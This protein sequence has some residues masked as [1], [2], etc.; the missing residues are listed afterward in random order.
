VPQRQLEF[1][2]PDEVVERGLGEIR[3]RLGIPEGFPVEV[4]GDARS[5]EPDLPDEDHTDIPF[6]TIDPPGSRDLDQA[7]HIERRGDGYR[8]RYAIADV[9]AFVRS[10]GP[11]DDEARERGLTMYGPDLRSPLYPGIL[12]EGMASL[13]AD[14][15][16]PA[17]VWNLDLDEAGEPID[18]DLRRAMVRSRGQYD[19]ASVQGQLDDG[20]A[21]TP[22]RLL[23]EVGRLRR[24]LEQERGGV[25][26]PIPDQQVAPYNGGWRLEY[27]SPLPVEGWNAQISLLTGMVAADLMIGAGIG[28]L[29]TLPPPRQEDIDRMRRIAHALEIAWPAHVGYPELVRSLD[30]GIPAHAAMLAEATTLFSGA[31]YQVLEPGTEAQRHAALATTYAHTTAPLRRLVDRFVGETCL[32]ISAGRDIPEW[33]S[34]ALP[35]LPLSMARARSISG[36]YEAACLNL[37]EAAVLSGKEGQTFTGVVVDVD[38][39]DPHGEVQLRHPAVHARI[40]GAGLALGDEIAVR[41]IEASVEDR[42]VVFAPV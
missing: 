3:D 12:S 14:E 16:R 35:T 10:G 21:P 19:Y 8:V 28:L 11:L 26:L 42:R 22:L 13:L 7:L 15:P 9:G 34:E 27:Q 17:L 25:S 36:N 33:V 2:A 38:R 4:L 37:V 41:L 18:V 29:R 39:D 1:V 40:D 24:L 23:A 31:S 6:V 30:S 5:I 20:T 32:A